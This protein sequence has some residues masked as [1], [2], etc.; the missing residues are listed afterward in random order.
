[1]SS[2]VDYILHKKKPLIWRRF[3]FFGRRELPMVANLP[4]KPDEAM[5][6]GYRMG[7]Q[8]GYGEG[9]VDGIDLGMD[10]GSCA[11]V[12]PTLSYTEPFDVC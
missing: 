11:A 12:Y 2:F 10:I 5:L 9:L 4:S 3:L 6:I 7:L 1:M 8:E